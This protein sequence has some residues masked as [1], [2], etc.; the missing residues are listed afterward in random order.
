MAAYRRV[1]VAGAAG[2]IGYHLSRRLLDDG[3][4]VIGVDNLITGGRRNFADLTADPRFTGIV[5]DIAAL[6]DVDGPIDCVFDLACPASPVDFQPLAIEIL[7]TCSRGVERLL[8]L[9]REKNAVFCHASTSECYGD[10]DP[11]HHPQTE[12]Y[13]GNVNP[14]GLRSPYDEGK[15]FAESLIMSHHRRHG[16]RTRLVR[17][18]NTYGPRMRADDGRVLPNFIGQALRNEPVTVYGDGSQTRS[19][20]YVDDMVDGII[21]LAGSDFPEPI[22][23]GN[24]VEVTIGEVA[25]EI[26]ALCKSSSEI[27]HKP[28]PDDDP[29]RRRPDITRARKIL[30]WEP[31]TDRK[32]GFARTVEYFRTLAASGGP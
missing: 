18:F 6:A 26:I 12:D 9:A 27:V 3:A 30:G 29:Q 4:E 28:M 23:I 20:C 15:R 17:I 32:T 25:R 16:L 13:F 22:N 19:F 31:A 11:A 24:P 8:D 1:I 5:A 7:R 21:R 14:I 10:P 2:F